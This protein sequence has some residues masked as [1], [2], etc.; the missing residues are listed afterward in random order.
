[1][2]C[3]YFS[4][5]YATCPPKT[6]ICVLDTACNSESC[7]HFLG[8][9]CDTDFC[10]NFVYFGVY[11]YIGKNCQCDWILEI[12]T[13]KPLHPKSLPNENVHLKYMANETVY[14][15]YLANQTGCLPGIQST[16]LVTGFTGGQEAGCRELCWVEDHARLQLNVPG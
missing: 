8:K 3:L 15:K 13:N 12:P 10:M 11:A 6:T 9:C 2:I 4:L 14:S 16:R 1:M 7:H 5:C